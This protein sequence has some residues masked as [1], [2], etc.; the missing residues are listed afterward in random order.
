MYD[1]I[2]DI[3]GYASPLKRLL[4]NMDY[5]EIGGVWQHPS[6][7]VIYVGDYIDRGP[8][9]KETLE[10]VRGMCENE[11]AIALMGNHE[12]NALAY[13]YRLKDGSFL[14][15]HTA[16]NSKQHHETLNQF[17]SYPQE[18]QEYLAWFY[19]LKLFLDLPGLRVVHACW[20]EED[21]DWLKSKNCHLMT[22]A[23]LLSS[24]K[25]GTR[26]YEAIN[27][28]LKGTEYTIPEE[29][30]WLDKDGNSRT[31]NRLKW[32]ADSRNRPY[33]EWLF[34]CPP[35]LIDKIID[36]NANFVPYSK[37]APPVFFGHYWLEDPYPVIQDSNVICLDFSIAKRGN[38][39][40]YRWDGEAQLDKEK[41]TFVGYTE[42]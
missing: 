30:V 23:L 13:A 22:E 40:A 41:F 36:E 12:Y 19:S 3:H 37:D 35:E 4:K 8:D 17:E 2:G 25:K 16:K 15:P 38:L 32:W 7:K 42:K 33:G 27:N 34:N 21:I 28:I 5:A 1:I 20:N 31:Q 29:F 11:K 39:V 9:I 24:Q 18:W 14:R 26:D 6:R 10:I